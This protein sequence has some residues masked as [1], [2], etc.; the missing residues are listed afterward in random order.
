MSGPPTSRRDLVPPVSEDDAEEL[1]QN[2]PCGYLSVTPTGTIVN[3]NDTF[4]RWTGWERDDLVG[5][6]RFAELLSPGGRLYHETHYMPLLQMQGQ[7]REIALEVMVPDGSRLP[8]LV[9][10]VLERDEVEAARVIR[11]VVFDATERRAYERELLRAKERAEDSERRARSL[12]RTLQRTLLPPSTPSIPGLEFAAA[13]RPAGEGAEVGGDFYDAFQV[14]ADDWVVVLGDVCGKGV[15]AAIVTALARHTI[16]AVVVGMHA[17]SQ[18]LSALN[19]VLLRQDGYRYCTLAMARLQRRPDGTWHATLGSGGHPAPLL[20]HPGED[21]VPVGGVG[22]LVGVLDAVE[23]VDREIDLRTGDVLT[24]FTD[25]VTEARRNRELYGE[26]RLRRCIQRHSESAA[27][28]V[29]AVLA[30]VVA[31][32]GDNLRDDVA[33]VSLRLLPT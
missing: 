30:D 13:F 19:E 16:R 21:A 2:A 17:P 1:Y 26:D 8:V 3:V 23:F 11:I 33:I 15:E 27:A 7:V 4:L 24:L 6:R 14:A 18:A 28:V 31:F 9:N 29:D 22:P 10:A 5:R 12:A 25:G 32:Q 20:S